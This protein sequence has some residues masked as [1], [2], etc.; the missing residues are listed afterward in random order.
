MHSYQ[1]ALNQPTTSSTD[2]ILSANANDGNTN[3]IWQAAGSDSNAWWQ[4]AFQGVFQVDSVQLVFP[5]P[6]NYQYQILVSADNVNWTMVVDQSQTSDSDQ[7]RTAVGN[8]GSGIGYVRVQFTNMPPGLVPGLAEVTVGGGSGL[9]Y[10]AG[11][12]GGTIIGTAG[13]SNNVTAN[14]K[15]AAMDWNTN[16]F[17]DGPDANDDWVGL[18]LGSSLKTNIVQV[19]YCPRINNATNSNFSGRMVGGIFQGANLPDFSDAVNLFTVTNAPSQG[20]FTLQ[21]ITN[22]TAFRYVRYLSGPNGF[23]DVAE[24]EFFQGVV[25]GPG[26]IWSGAVNGSWDGATTNWLNNGVSATYQDGDAVQFDDTALGNSTVS[27]TGSVAPS[28]MVVNNSA[29][30]YA[31]SGDAMTGTGGLAKSGAGRLTLSGANT[32]SG[33]ITG[34]A[35][36]IILA[37]S[38]SGNAGSVTA[39]PA[40]TG[41]INLSGGALSVD[42]GAIRT[43]D[44]NLAIIAGTTNILGSSSAGQNL[45]LNGPLTGGGTLLNQSVTPAASYSVFLLG[46][47]SQFTGTII[48]TGV[49]SGNGANWRLGSSGGTSDLSQAAVVLNGG[50]SKNF[51]FQDNQNTVTLKLGSVSGNGYFQGAYGG[52]TVDNLMIG[53]LNSSTTFS[54]QV[55]VNGNNMANFG[56]IK[57]G[58]GTLALIGANIYTGQTMVSN[59][60]LIVSTV[61]AGKGSFA[62]NDGAGLGVTNLSTTSASISNLTLGVS[63]PTTLEFQNVSNLTKALFSISNLTLNGSCTVKITGTNNLAVGNTYPLVAYSGGFAGVFTNLQLQMPAGY[64]WQRGEQCTSGFF[65]RHRRGSP[66]G[67]AGESCYD[68]RQRASRGKLERGERWAR[69]VTISS[70]RRSTA[71]L[72]RWLAAT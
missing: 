23:C 28:S 54:G 57:V 31:I 45:F 62:V 33:G 24:L 69:P 21:P 12:L 27:V 60:E 11:Q 35:G 17:F 4:V 5:T 51:G 10:N 53:F 32:F 39:G 34:S 47:L 22:T 46:D 1:L 40:G 8:F 66:A 36:T 19:G 71:G 65:E 72:M 6:G 9:V 42:S 64:L 26:V 52:S 20:A 68:G 67:S 61:F 3:T 15:E 50:N 59:G 70:V 37:G 7:S 30:T 56:L 25:L 16:T 48:Y 49:T 29:L 38:T 43:I 55:G 44:N 41:T 58:A 13:S 14:V 2:V 63:G 18:D